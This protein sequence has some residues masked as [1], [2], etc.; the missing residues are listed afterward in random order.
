MGK[1]VIMSLSITTPDF[2]PSG[3]IDGKQESSP[4]TICPPTGQVD[5]KPVH[6]TPPE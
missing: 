2:S 1:T 6:G 5:L 3:H 4:R